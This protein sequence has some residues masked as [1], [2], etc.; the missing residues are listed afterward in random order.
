MGWWWHGPPPRRGA[1]LCPAEGTIDRLFLEHAAGRP[2]PL[3]P[4]KD[5]EAQMSRHPVPGPEPRVSDPRGGLCSASQVQEPPV[6][7]AR[8]HLLTQ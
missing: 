5:Q 4:N 6:D 7:P 1:R 2:Q 3:L 8:F